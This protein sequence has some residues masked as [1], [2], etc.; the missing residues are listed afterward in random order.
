MSRFFGQ[1]YFKAKYFAAELL[2]GVEQVVADVV[3]NVGGWLGKEH[4]EQQDQ[5]HPSA[6]A[7]KLL[8]HSDDEQSSECEATGISSDSDDTPEARRQSHAQQRQV[9]RQ[10]SAGGA[11]AVAEAE[12]D[13]EERYF[14]D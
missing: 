11:L 4:K 13:R 5:H 6:H 1:A 14:D 12:R 2:H 7:T 9:R 10:W 3:E 8:S